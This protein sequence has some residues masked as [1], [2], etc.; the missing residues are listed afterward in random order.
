[1][2]NLEMGLILFGGSSFDCAPVL[3][4]ESTGAS[5]RMTLGYGIASAEEGRSENG[6]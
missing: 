3:S 1:M 4:N 5:L 6:E 2:Q